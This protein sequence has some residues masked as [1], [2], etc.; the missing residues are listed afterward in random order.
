MQLHCSSMI[1]SRNTSAAKASV[2]SGRL[3]KEPVP[4]RSSWT[5]SMPSIATIERIDGVMWH[6]R[7]YWLHVF[8]AGV[9]R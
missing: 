8:Q 3:A 9:M 2:T 1:R 5:S 4:G 7:L 6:T